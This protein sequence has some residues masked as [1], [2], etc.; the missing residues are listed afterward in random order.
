VTDPHRRVCPC[1]TWNDQCGYHKWQ[2]PQHHI[3]E[4]TDPDTYEQL[5]IWQS[6]YDYAMR[7]LSELVTDHDPTPPNTK[8]REDWIN[9][10][11]AAY[12]AYYYAHPHPFEEWP[13]VTTRRP[14]GSH[15][16]LIHK[17]P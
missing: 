11:R 12:D 1:G 8:T 10:R 7:Q 15:L 13:D 4:D 16:D 14:P 5:L 17:S 6:G 9:E 2:T 3:P